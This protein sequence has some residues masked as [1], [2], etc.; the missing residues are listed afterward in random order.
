MPSQY[1]ECQ[2]ILKHFAGRIGRFL[3]IGAYDGLAF[4]NTRMLM[5]LGWYGVCVEPSP[6][7]FPSL[8]VKTQNF[9]RVER[10]EAA[11][12][13]DDARASKS[14]LMWV[15]QDC[16]ST[17]VASHRQRWKHHDM[18][19][20]KVPTLRWYELLAQ[21]PEPYDFINIDT[22]GMNWEL[23]RDGPLAEMMC[24]ELDPPAHVE[25]IKGHLKAFGLENQK[26]IGGNLLA[27]RT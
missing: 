24:I 18:V 10:V 17:M 20:V 8:F 25:Q 23:V 7:V 6:L 9:P 26:V 16:T 13:P 11:I 5:E 27:W 14:A 12:V 22:E 4:S 2:E 3:D 19:E 15:T 1:G 21:H